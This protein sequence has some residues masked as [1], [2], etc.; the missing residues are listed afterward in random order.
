MALPG[1]ADLCRQETQKFRRREAFRDEFCY[2]IFRRAVCDRNSEAWS[3]LFEAYGALARGW[4]VRHPARPSIHEDDEFLVNGL[5]E[6]FIRA[7]G[8][9]RFDQF[10]TLASLLNYLKLCAHSIILDE[11][12]RHDRVAVDSTDRL[13]E[14]L[15]EEPGAESVDLVNVGAR[16]LWDAIDRSLVDDGERRVVYLRLALGLTPREVQRREPD[17]FA[18]VADVYRIYRNALDRL[19]RATEIQAFVD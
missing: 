6:R 17:Q 5:F 8:P 2:E 3:E 16:E 15:G 12:R 13:L 9:E 10:P 4:I 11:V 1:L 14:E 19:R 7:V 18:T